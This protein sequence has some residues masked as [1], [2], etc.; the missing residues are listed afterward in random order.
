MM[1]TLWQKTENAPIAKKE[2][3]FGNKRYVISF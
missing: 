1:V 2:E 3:N